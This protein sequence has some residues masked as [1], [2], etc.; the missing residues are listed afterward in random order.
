MFCASFAEFIFLSLFYAL[1]KISKSEDFVKFHIFIFFLAIILFGN[2]LP[3]AAQVE[4]V[5]GQVTSSVTDSFAGGISGDG[6]FIVFESRGDLGTVRD[7]NN[8]PNNADGNRE[9]FLFDY[10]QR[11]IFQ[12]TNTKSLLKNTAL[13]VTFDNIRVDI[14]N[15]RPVISNDGRWIAFGSN[16]TTS[17]PTTPNSTNPG[18]FDANAFTTGTTTPTNPLTSDGN[19]EI[20][21]Y[22]VPVV[23]PVA[24]LSA[25]EEIAF[26]NLAGGAFTRV[27]NSLASRLPVAGSTTAF[28]VIADDNRDASIEDNGAAISFTSNRDLVPCPTTPTAACGNAATFDND[29]IFA[30]VRGTAATR[31][32]TAT[33]RGAIDNPIYN[34]NS[35]ISN[36]AGGRFRV[37]FVG[38]GNVPVVGTTGTNAD[39]NE[40]IFFVDLESSGDLG[41]LRRQITNTT[42]AAAGDVVNILNYGRRMSRDGRYI[43]FDSYADLAN[44]HMGVNQPG[45]GT[46]VYDAE[47]QTFR[48]ILARSNADAAAAGGDVQRY[49]G[50][51][52]DI[53]A[54]GNVQTAVVLETRMNIR[55]SDG[56]VPTNADEGLNNTTARQAQVYSFLLNVTPMTAAPKYIRLTKLPSPAFF[57]AS[58]Q[59]LTT[60]T[61]KR[62]AFNLGQTE[63]GSG[64]PDL[65]TEVYYLIRP[66]AN[67]VETPATLSFATGASRIPISASPV[68]TPSPTATPTPSPSPSPT[69]TPTPQ[70][71][72]VQGVSPGMLAILD[73][74]PGTN[75]PLVART[76]VGGLDR[77]F[78]LP[79][80]LSGVTMTIN[81][82]AVGLKSVGQ[83]QIV[84]VVPPG[85]P[86]ATAGTV[87][88]VVVN[89][90]GTIFRG[91]VTV[92]QARPDIFTNLPSPGPGGRARVFN[93]T[94]RVLLTE[95]FPIRT[96]RLRGSRLVPTVLR[97]YVTG[98]NN[99][100]AGAFTI[101]IGDTQITGTNVVLTGATLIEPGVY[102]VDFTLPASLAGAG[103]QQI[104]VRVSVNGIV[105]ESRLGDTAPRLSIL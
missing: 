49:P 17:T 4:S 1:V 53:D 36:L 2:I 32:I 104:I 50:F 44:E 15:V 98:V 16:A 3:A 45:F 41:T 97:V 85:L 78:T 9:I 39:L 101:V 54:A 51:S 103:D 43:A 68:P 6:R 24:D 79:I 46:F 5:V 35:T 73:Y 20:W 100:A 55:A 52:T 105:Y 40:E 62:M 33:P 34:A 91:N 60:N 70:P 21:L 14:V 66:D 74:N 81:G 95:P 57:L 48:R 28:P 77:R 71:P 89:N 12:I 64:N 65:A 29:E 102:A 72:A 94:N 47:T 93:A 22:Q 99:L 13:P 26:A 83:R 63:T 96:F 58:I 27:T 42:R 11:R 67:V 37:A 92:V 10:A 25:G 61:V 80:E 87:Y 82:A 56:A 23:P 30:Y 69:T 8:Q 88:P 38:N 59:A 90:N 19:T 86:A 7:S 84:F 75:Q 31:Q 76:A 18:N